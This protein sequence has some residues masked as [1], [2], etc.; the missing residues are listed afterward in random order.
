MA[1][2]VDPSNS[3][4]TAGAT[5]VTGSARST[6]T[7]GYYKVADLGLIVQWGYIQTVAQGATIS[8]T[9]PIAFPNACFFASNIPTNANS[10]P[11][12]SPTV[13]AIT[14]TNFTSQ[15]QTGITNNFRWVAIGF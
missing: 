15:N 1:V 6:T 3:T 9:F 14:T 10:I 13:S 8:P 11:Q 5:S 2:T 7:N 4:I 12:M